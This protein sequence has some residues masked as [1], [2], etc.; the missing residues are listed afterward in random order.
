MNPHTD[1]VAAQRAG[2]SSVAFAAALFGRVAAAAD[3][4]VF[5]SPYSVGAGL[6]LTMEGAKG[7][8]AGQLKKALGYASGHDMEQLHHDLVSLIH[9]VQCVL[10]FTFI[11]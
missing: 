7:D 1:S 6:A 2:E 10:Y 4:N 9:S 11:I 5:M 8:T 3:A